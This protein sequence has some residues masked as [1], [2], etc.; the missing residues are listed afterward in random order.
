TRAMKTW[1]ED[2][3]LDAGFGRDSAIIAIGGGS[4]TDLAGFVAAT[5]CRG[6]PWCTVPTTLLAMVDASI[7]GKTAIDVA[8]GKNLIGAFH[9]PSAVFAD[10]DLL[11]TLP[12]EE[13]R[14]GMAEAIKT[15]MLSNAALLK[16]IASLRDLSVSVASPGVE[17]VIRHCMDFKQA[18]V[19]DDM[20]EQGRRVILNFGHTI[21]HAIEQLSGYAFSHGAC[22]AMGL[23]VES[24][25]L[26]RLGH[27]LPDERE[28]LLSVLTAAGLPTMVPDVAD[29]ALLASMRMDKKS[30]HGAARF[31]RL[32]GMGDTSEPWLIGAET[33]LILHCYKDCVST[34]APAL[35]CSVSSGGVDEIA[36]LRRCIDALDQELMVH[37]TR[38]Q[39]IVAQIGT[40]KIKQGAAVLDQGREAAVLDTARRDAK[41]LGLDEDAALAVMQEIIRQSRL[42]Q[43][44]NAKTGRAVE[45]TNRLVMGV[46]VN[47]QDTKAIN[48]KGAKE[49]AP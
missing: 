18:V 3:M 9:E 15:A 48:N 33:E 11:A 46:T 10:M 38:R 22:V 4:L 29:A 24:L 36:S 16:D 35:S 39:G 41:Q 40:Q 45:E 7:G 43:E 34:D 2:S 19:A 49:D 47:E 31:V 12:D 26:E 27:I 8:Q 17:R 21:G 25:L 13:L 44:R 30:S 32:S 28:L 23:S 20:A 14:N 42:L 6:I 5:Y 1:I 37:L